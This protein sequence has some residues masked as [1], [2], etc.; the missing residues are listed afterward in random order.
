[1]NDKAKFGAEPVQF[2]DAG[3]G[4]TTEAKVFS[5]MQTANAES[6]H[7][8]IAHKLFGRKTSERGVKG[9]RNHSVNAGGGQ[10]AHALV[11]GREQMGRTR[12]AKKSLGMRVK[13]DGNAPD[14]K[15]TCFIHHGG[16]NF[17]MPT[18]YA[19]EVDD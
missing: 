5:L 8:N 9:Q 14:S 2:L 6:I 10:Q 17:L 4:V 18:I 19:I 12:R 16:K 15:R 13:G 11:H 7:Q 3:L 1:M